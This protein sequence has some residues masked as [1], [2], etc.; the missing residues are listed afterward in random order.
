MTY[1]KQL[2]IFESMIEG[3]GFISKPLAERMRPRDLDE[4]VGQSHVVGPGSLIRRAIEEDKLFS[5][6]LWGPPGCGKTSLANIIARG[7]KSH[8]IQ[9]SAVLSGVKDI[10]SAIDEAKRQLQFSKKRTILFVDEVHRFSKSQQDSFLKH[11]ESGLL[12]LIGATTENPSF[13]LIP[14]LMSRC[15][16][17]TLN[18][19]SDKDI[20]TVIQRA[21]NDNK[22]GLGNSNFSLAKNAM[23]HIIK[24]SDGDVRAALNALEITATVLLSQKE[25]TVGQAHRIIKIEDLENALQRK[26]LM[27]DKSG[28]EHYNLISAL[29]KSLR[30]SDPDAA[31][32]WLMRMIEAGEDPMYL[33]RRMVRFA[34][35]DIGNADP[36]ALNVALNAVEAFRFLG[37]PEGDLALLQA[38][39]YL[40]TAP[41]SNS[42]YQAIKSVKRVINE[43]GAQPVPYHIRNAPTKLM[44]SIGYGKNYKY[45]HDYKD[46]FV[47][48]EYLPDKLQHEIFYNPT[49]RG[50]EKTVKRWL[51]KWRSLKKN[52]KKS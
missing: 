50:Y 41:K 36:N 43:T 8:F 24:I 30:G 13:E 49:E 46:A 27:Y 22:R 15:R 14:A 2:D 26:A 16:V 40:A 28:E 1:D 34:S 11:V 52:S 42:L 48:Q 35:E 10:R 39:V 32:Y 3:D 6:I 47:P 38:A 4:F 31:A 45:A 12:T 5:T 20:I 21:L 37:H 18:A 7:T 17:I 25:K 23:H 33:G 44:K 51:D 19:L 9:I 29:H